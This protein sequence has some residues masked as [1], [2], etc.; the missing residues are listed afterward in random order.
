MNLSQRG[1]VGADLRR[2]VTG[3]NL[4]IS[5]EHQLHMRRVHHLTL[6]TIVGDGCERS[7]PCKRPRESPDTDR[8]PA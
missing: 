5:H 6:R 1:G 4:N 2:G 3:I 8:M 7:S